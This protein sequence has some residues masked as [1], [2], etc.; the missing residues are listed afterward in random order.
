LGKNKEYIYNKLP[1]IE[2]ILVANLDNFLE[3][4][5][6]LIIINKDE[7]INNLIK[8]DLENLVIID[9]SRIETLNKFEYYEGICW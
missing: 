4:L 9:L 6:I 8:K 3:H 5:E 2:E 7:E 1:H